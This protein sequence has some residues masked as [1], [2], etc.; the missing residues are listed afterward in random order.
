MQQRSA[1]TGL[2]IRR[3]AIVAMA[4][5][6]LQAGYLHS[7]TKGKLFPPPQPRLPRADAAWLAALGFF[8]SPYLAA[9][10]AATLAALILAA[11][12]LH[13]LLGRVLAL[14]AWRP[15][16]E[17][18]YSLYL[19]HELPKAAAIHWF[20]PPGALASLAARSPLPA[21]WLICGGTLSAAYAAAWLCWWLVERRF[22]PLPR[23]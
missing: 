15:L 13:A 10:I 6:G 4:A 7:V 18:S 20:V 5:I 17:L 12:P 21:L 16:A 9:R 22:Q 8:G 11:D 23:P 2:P 19:L 1:P 14:P 3:G